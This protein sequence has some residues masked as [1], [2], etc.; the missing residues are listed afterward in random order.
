VS[1][2]RKE[3]LAKNASLASMAMPGRGPQ[4]P[5]GVAPVHWNTQSPT[6]SVRLVKRSLAIPTSTLAR[7]VLLVTKVRIARNAHQVSYTQISG[8]LL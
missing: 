7:I 3:T 1:T 5:A 6:I 8:F 4:I 2:T